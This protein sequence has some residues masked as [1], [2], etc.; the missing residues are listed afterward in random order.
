MF[1]VRSASVL[2]VC[3]CVACVTF[4]A[5]SQDKK[6]KGKI[7][8][9]GE[10][11]GF[12]K[13]LSARFALW[14]GKSNW[15]FRVTTA[16][17]TR[18]FRG[19]VRAENGFFEKVHSHHLEKTG[20]LEDHWK[21]DMPARQTLAFDFKTHKEIDGI[22][23]HVSKTTTALY[24]QLLIDNEA[25]PKH[26]YIGHAGVHPHNIPFTLPAHPGKKK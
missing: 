22:D 7:D 16:G 6:G 25:H 17:K 11:A 24:F 19:V 5:L 10:P 18:H 12:H 3:A 8:P 26:V 1:G 9:N 21:L 2:T 15:H 14:H 13:G 23:F 20:G 4:P